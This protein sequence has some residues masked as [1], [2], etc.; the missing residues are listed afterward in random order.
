MTFTCTCIKNS[1]HK[2]PWSQKHQ[3]YYQVTYIA[4]NRPILAETWLFS[5]PQPL[6]RAVTKLTR[7]TAQLYDEDNNDD[8]DSEWWWKLRQHDDDDDGINN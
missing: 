5:L 3:L 6:N 4:L 2:K 8:D 7:I 1:N